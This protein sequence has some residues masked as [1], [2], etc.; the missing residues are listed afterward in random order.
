MMKKLLVAA[1]IVCAA[2]SAQAWTWTVVNAG[3][4]NGYKIG[5]LVTS[6]AV[7]SLDT[8][9]LADFNEMF[10][11]DAYWGYAGATTWK[12][13]YAVVDSVYTTYVVNGTAQGEVQGMSDMSSITFFLCPEGI[14]PGKEYVLTKTLYDT[15]GNN[16]FDF[17]NAQTLSSGKFMTDSVPEPTSGLL[18]LLGVAGLA[19]KRKQT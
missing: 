19:L 4:Y 9:A 11:T 15:S 3:A 13:Y 2:V 7:E 1:A 14:A 16:T 8:R 17:T 6:S 5:N 18:L 10:L 12:E